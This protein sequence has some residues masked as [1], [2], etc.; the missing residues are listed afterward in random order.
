TSVFLAGG[1]AGFISEDYRDH[2]NQVAE[3]HQAVA[4]IIKELM[5]VET[6]AREFSNAILTDITRWEDADRAGKRAVP[7]YYRIPG[8]PHPPSAA[9]HSTVASGV[10]RMLGAKLRSDVDYVYNEVV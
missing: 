3:M 4:G 7:G 9:W 2:R 8:A 1:S 10:A 6:K 5:S